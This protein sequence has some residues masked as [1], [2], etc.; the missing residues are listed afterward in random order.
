MKDEQLREAAK[1]VVDAA[2]AARKA[3]MGAMAR[4]NAP[5]YVR[6]W[7]QWKGHD[8]WGLGDELYTCYWIVA[9]SVAVALLFALTA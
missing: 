4:L 5:F 7:H 9:L 1:G 8:G 2:P 6:A 3:I